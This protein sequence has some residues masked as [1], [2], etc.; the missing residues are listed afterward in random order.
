MSKFVLN[1][2][3]GNGRAVTARALLTVGK[4][5]WQNNQV[6]TEDWPKI[7]PTF[8]FGQMPVLQHNGKQYSQSVAIN[9]YLAKTFKLYGKN[10]E[11]EYQIDSLFCTYEDLFP[12]LCKF[13][14]NQD[15]SK[16]KELKKEAAEKLK[17]FAEKFEKRYVSLGKGKYYLGNHFSAA[18]VYLASGLYNICH[19]LKEESNFEK[20]APNLFALIKRVK[21]NELK[22]F[23]N[24]YYVEGAPF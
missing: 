22:E 11:E 7:K 8:E 13:S 17:F 1:Y 21:D 20:Y 16:A 19:V 3:G 24:T 12:V 10:I 9:I 5:D 14:F 4:A 23:Y 15:A 2:F 6:K 18:D